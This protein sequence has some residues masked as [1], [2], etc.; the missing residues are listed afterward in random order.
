MLNKM[1]GLKVSLLSYPNLYL[2]YPADHIED[3]RVGA[4]VDSVEDSTESLSEIEGVNG[5]KLG[6]RLRRMVGIDGL[7]RD[8]VG[9][10]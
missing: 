6:V 4:G 10:S 2:Y 1:L 8:L 5:E 9:L 3:R 7:K